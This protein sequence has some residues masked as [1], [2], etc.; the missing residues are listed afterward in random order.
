MCSTSF[1]EQLEIRVSA[2]TAGCEDSV[3]VSTARGS[4][5]LSV[6]AAEESGA[7]GFFVDFPPFFFF[8]PAAEAEGGGATA[9]EAQSE[10]SE[11]AGDGADSDLATGE[12]DVE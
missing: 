10:G 4:E 7:A 6:A 1:Q 5:G 2:A 11:R 8:A 12:S 3:V 9:G